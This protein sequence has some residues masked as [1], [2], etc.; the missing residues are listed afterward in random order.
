MPGLRPRV[1]T[2]R[3]KRRFASRVPAIARGASAYSL[4]VCGLLGLLT[5]GADADPRRG[6]AAALRCARHRGP[7]ESGTW[8]DPDVVFGFNRLSI[9]DVEHSHQ[10]LRWGLPGTTAVTRSSSTARSTTT[11]SCATS[12][13]STG[14]RSRPTATPR[15]SSPPTTTGARPRWRACAG[16]SRSSSGTPRS[17]C[18]S[19]RATRSASSR[20]SCAPARRR[21]VREREEEPAGAGPGVREGSVARPGRARPAAL[22]DP[23]VRAGAG[24]PAPVGAAG[25][26]GL[27]VHGAARRRG[28]GG[29]LLHAGAARAA[30]D[31]PHPADR[32]R[33]ARLGG[34]AHARRRHRGRVPL[35][36]HRLH[37]HRGAGQGAQP[38]PDH[39]HHGL[40]ARGLLGGG[41]GRRVGRGDRRPARHPHGQAGRDDGGAAADRLV[42]RRPGGR[43][44]AG[45]A[46]VHRPR[47][48]PP[49][50]GGAV[51]GGRR[52]AVRR[53]HDLQGAAVAGAVRE[54]AGRAAR[55]AGASRHLPEGMRGKDLLRR[56]ALPLEQRYYGNAR[57]FRD[58]QL[59]GVL[60]RYDPRR[61]HIDITAAH[62]AESAGGTRWR[63]CS[64]STCSPGCA[65][66]SSSRRTR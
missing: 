29:A 36:R 8:H 31:P 45:A 53:L 44:R 30:A 47:G 65:A 33:A 20:C 64:T 26:V 60:R 13:A 34:Q 11:S 38:G 22:P 54:G 52:R 2:S 5:S 10:P 17:G 23:A 4:A 14:P 12:S 28:R 58:D 3:D 51:R 62:Y 9:I 27:L 46:V 61:G 55:A 39:V 63:G 66:T 15:R 21:G 50:Q 41:R 59:A 25:R 18:C 19:A 57:I 1:E 37:G 42:P 48:P 49:R 35:R 56:G 40:R 43:P 32:R 7:D 24:D 6:R 16:C